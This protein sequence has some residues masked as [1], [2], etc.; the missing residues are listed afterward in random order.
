M[1]KIPHIQA[2][3]AFGAGAQQAVDL[4]PGASGLFVA[5][6]L[7]PSFRD[8]AGLRANWNTWLPK[9]RPHVTPE[10]A[11]DMT[12]YADNTF[13]KADLENIPP[14]D[15]PFGVPKWMGTGDMAW[16]TS[17]SQIA[18]KSLAAEG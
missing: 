9:I 12:P 7:H 11:A 13:K 6:P 14:R 4:W 5:K 2:V 16:R 15:L 18:W 1:L 17:T 3:I 10:V 8:D